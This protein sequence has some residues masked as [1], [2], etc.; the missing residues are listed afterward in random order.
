MPAETT[1]SNRLPHSRSTRPPRSFI[2]AGLALS[3]ASCGSGSS[4][5]AT[6]P[7]QPAPGTC[8]PPAATSTSFYDGVSFLFQGDCKTQQD[9]TA[10]AFTRQAIAVLRGR[11]VDDSG[12]P[13]AEVAISAPQQTAWGTTTSA[14]DGSY[15]FAVQGGAKDVL[16]FELKG[17]IASQRGIFV[18]WNRVA[19][20]DD[21]ALIKPSQKISAV[22]LSGSGGWQTATGDVVEDA[23]GKRTLHVL[24]PPGVHA[25]QVLADDTEAAF[26]GGA[27]RLTEFTQG[28]QGQ[29]A[30]PAGLPATSAYTYASA[31]SFDEAVDAKQ[32]KFDQPVYAYLD[33]FLQ[34]TVG[35]SVPVGSYRPADDAWEASA[36]GVVVAAVDDGGQLG[37]DV[38]GDGHADVGA[39]LTALSI[40]PAEI[41]ALAGFATAGASFWRVPLQHFSAVD[42]NWGFVAPPGAGPGT[43]GPP[44]G[45]SDTAT[46]TCTPAASRFECENQ[47]LHDDIALSGSSMALH[48]SSARAPGREV[49]FTLRIPITGDTVPPN[50]KRADVDVDVLGEVTHT[51]YKGLSKHLTN[52]FTWDGK[53]AWGRV[54]PGRTVAHVRVS[55]A[56]DGVAYSNTSHFGEVPD[57]TSVSPSAT[58]GELVFTSSYELPIGLSDASELGLGGWTL[59]LHHSYDPET[60]VLY[61]GDGVK[62]DSASIPAL[63]EN[64]TGQET[65]G[66]SGDN[67]PAAAAELD[68][69]EGVAVLPDGSVIVS[70]L[71]NH[72]LRKIDTAGAISTFAGTGK[73]GTKGDGGPAIRAQLSS[74]RALAAKADGTVCVADSLE[75]AARVR[76]IDPAGTIRTVLGGGSDQPGMTDDVAGTDFGITPVLDFQFAFARDGSLVFVN[77]GVFVLGTNGRVTRLAGGGNGTANDNGDGGN[78]K[79]ATFGLVAGVAIAPDG[80][81]LVSDVGDNRVRRIA[82]DGTISTFAGTG[83]NDYSGDGGLAPAAKL[84]QPSRVAVAADGSV[85]IAEWAQRRVRK[86]LPSGVITT[87]A[88]GGEKSSFPVAARQLALLLVSQMATSPDGSLLVGGDSR[89]LR[90]RTPLP[91][92]GPDTMIVPADD[93]SELYVFDATGRHLQTLDA[94][95]LSEKLHFAY[96]AAGYLTSV[97]DPDANALLID[98]DAKGNATVIHAPFGQKT[99]LA[100][101]AAGHLAKVTDALARVTAVT[102]DDGGLLTQLV[103]RNGGVHAMQYGADGRLTQDSSPAGSTWSLSRTDTDG[104]HITVTTALGRAR[105]HDVLISGPGDETRSIEHANGTRTAWTI[106]PDG[107]TAVTAPDGTVTEDR[108]DADPRLGMVASFLGQHTVTLPS[109]LAATWSSAKTATLSADGVTPSGLQTTQTDTDGTWTTT[110]DG[111]A[112]TSTTATPAGRSFRTGLDARGRLIDVEAP[113]VTPVTVTYDA[114]G[115]IASETQGDRIVSF[116]YGDNGYL[117]EVHDAEGEIVQTMRDVA[118]RVTRIARAD[119]ASIELGYD[120]DDNLVSVTPPGKPEHTLTYTKDDQL[121]SYTDPGGVVTSYGYDLDRALTGVTNPDGA[122]PAYTYDAAGRRSTL[123]YTGGRVKSQYAATSGLLSKLTGPTTDSLSYA[124]DGSAL[125]SVEARGEAPGTVS[126]TLDGQLRVATETVG[127]SVVSLSRDA[128]GLLTGAGQWTAT[129]DSA[130]GQIVSAAVRDVSFAYTY[131]S[132]GEVESVK[133]TTAAGPLLDFAYSYD[134]LSRLLS[135]TEGNDS[136]TSIATS[137]SYDLAGRLGTVS[138]AGAPTVTYSYDPNGNRTDNDAAADD[139]DRLTAGFGATYTYTPNGELASKTDSLGRTKYGYDGLGALVSATL[140]AGHALSYGLDALGRRVSRTYDGAVT[141]RWVYR[142]GLQIVA[143]VDA[144]GTVVSRFVYGAVSQTPAYMER[145]GDVYVFVTDHLGSVRDVVRSS[146]DTL[147]QALTYDAWGKV[148]SDTNPGF[149]PFGFA[150]GLYDAATG[151]V[152]F[153][154]RDYDASSGTWTSKDPIRFQSGSPNIYGYAQGDPVNHVDSS[155]LQSVPPKDPAAVAE[156]AAAFAARGGGSQCYLGETPANPF[157]LA[158]CIVSADPRTSPLVTFASGIVSTPCDCLNAGLLQPV[159][160]PCPPESPTTCDDGP[161][162]D[163]DSD[164]APPSP[165]NPAASCPEPVEANYTPSPV[166]GSR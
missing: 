40:T 47:V 118:G 11:V 12:K 153:G 71:A 49:A 124:Y 117:S 67:G 83:A 46:P 115:H 74:P 52:D 116:V 130:S 93:G 155:G 114:Q 79:L 157:C 16:R 92:V 133:V 96:D 10:A 9:V 154:A 51:E 123:A 129:R 126:W 125:T 44:T 60:Q 53:D 84:Q 112:L 72:R 106:L 89:V 58:R 142:N 37:L 81:V 131:T 151:L 23:S 18:G 39:K 21:V 152:R 27:L 15:S 103:D 68:T 149:Q 32:V 111:A 132:F 95:T 109:G 100:Y 122:K 65:S 119:G 141:Q 146:D 88:G 66:F 144:V 41:A 36:S 35:A 63:A 165:C 62:L 85:Y 38:D 8:L 156:G 22:D 128:D 107:T 70:D 61:R 54:W 80:S 140:P 158:A 45:G 69:V 31:L 148:T 13:L 104:G 102:M 14:A 29:K 64:L 28:D 163:A 105:T 77:G 56:Y 120:K 75:L 57:G 55:L 108:R 161:D 135:T 34:M 48:Y 6:K 160:G 17:H 42:F 98:R 101:D 166:Q 59:S 134:K 30:M 113:G 3:L 86:V 136:G 138:S 110:Y 94:L 147:V 24:F 2:V 145:D 7:T 91:G 99:K 50:V 97:E 5:P 159:Y 26:D 82:P 20:V 43:G 19:M 139:Q 137:Y 162:G 1:R 127:A 76:C 25:T 121:A 150:G 33:N 4:G 73:D 164:P 78:A 143:E 87:F 90:F